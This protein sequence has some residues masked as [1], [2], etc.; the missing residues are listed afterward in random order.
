MMRECCRCTNQATHN[1]NFCAQHT[2]L[3]QAFTPAPA[4]PADDGKWLDAP[5]K[6]G[7]WV[8]W[9]QEYKE[10]ARVMNGLLYGTE[11]IGC[12]SLSKWWYM[13]PIPPDYVPPLPTSRSVTLTAKVSGRDKSWSVLLMGEGVEL[14]VRFYDT[15]E[16]AMQWS[17][18]CFG[19]EPTVEG[20]TP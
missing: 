2:P 4:P 17:R 14:D 7:I 10:T 3:D 16:K 13:G 8:R 18:I 11:P 6:D 9:F 19:I 12:Y 5:T 15:K 20:E 1:L